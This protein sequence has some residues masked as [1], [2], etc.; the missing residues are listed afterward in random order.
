LEANIMLKNRLSDV[1]VGTM[2]HIA[3]LE[4]PTEIRRRLLDIGCTEGTPV[5][6][7][8]TGPSGEP[9]A[10][11]IRGAVMALRREDAKTIIVNEH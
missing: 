6:C 10:Y 5:T 7:L 4:S 11:G 9:R 1:A 3:R 2:A 8:F